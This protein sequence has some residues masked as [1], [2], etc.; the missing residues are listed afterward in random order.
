MVNMHLN[1]EVKVDVLLGLFVAALI[2]SN[3]LGGKITTIVGVPVSVGIFAFP[4]TFLITDIVEEVLGKRRV[5]R[6]ILVGVVSLALM[7]VLIWVARVVAPAERSVDPEAFNAVFGSSL[8]II[9][10]SLVA[11]GL[12]Q[13]HDV[14]AFDFWKKKTHGRFLWLRNN[15]ST[16]MSQF[17]DTV[18]FMYL[19]FYQLTPK[20]TVGFVFALLVPYFLFKIAFAVLDTPLVYF[21]VA[22][23]RGG[24]KKKL[25]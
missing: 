4:L 12:G 7:F 1:Q 3:I 5:R 13:L 20:F 14:W 8:R 6:F 15:F 9:F 16:W 18:I 25:V 17:V 10:A 2:A 19:A 24:E 22:W 21:G 11:F 23:L